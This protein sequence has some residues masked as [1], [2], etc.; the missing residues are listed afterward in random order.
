MNNY[1]VKKPLLP[2]KS[3]FIFKLIFGDQRNVDIL[4]EFLK[5]ILR[6]PDDEYEQ[7]TIVDPHVKRESLKDKSAILDV[8]VHTKS[9]NVIHVEIQV[10]KFPE[11]VERTLFYQSKMITEQIK[12]GEDWHLIKRTVNIIITDF[13]FV[14]KSDKYHN[15]FRYTNED[16][17]VLTDLTEINT[18]ELRKLP[19]DSDNTELW[20]W[21]KFIKTDSEEEMD[22]L[23]EKSVQFSKAVGFLKELSADERTR[24]LYEEREN[25][26]RDVV[27]MVRG[28]VIDVA[29]NLISAGA[30]LDLIAQAT[31]LSNKEIEELMR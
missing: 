27:S 7:L 6:I 10:C 17:V 1:S 28:A 13:E 8:K 11:M 31:K 23:A 2:V 26:R 3:D 12:S 14:S 18:L 21:L 16:G 25:A 19:V 9:G 5:P 22:M 4:A 24:M 20:N 29:R 30:S 15:R